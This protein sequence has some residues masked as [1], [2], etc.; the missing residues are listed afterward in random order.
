MDEINKESSQEEN[1]P[2]FRGLYRYVK[3]PVKALDFI[4]VACILVIVVVVAIE[5]I[6][7]GYTVTFDSR[8]GTDVVAQKHDYGDTLDLPEPPT[9]EGYTFTGWFK[10][11]AC[12]IQWD[13]ATDIVESDMD[14]YAG[15]QKNE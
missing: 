5:L 9:R 13:M 11:P 14:L 7:P 2:K 4:I 6:N 12:E 1:L 3:I 15:W 10:D 8:G